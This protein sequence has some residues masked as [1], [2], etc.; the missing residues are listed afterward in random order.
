VDLNQL[1]MKKKGKEIV[2]A[3][4]VVSMKP[5]ARREYILKLNQEGDARDIDAGEAM[6]VAKAKNDYV[7]LGY[8]THDA[9]MS[10]PEMYGTAR[11]QNYK[12][13][14]AYIFYCGRLG[15]KKSTVATVAIERLDMMKKLVKREPERV[16]EF[17][18][19]ARRIGTADFKRWCRQR[20]K[21]GEKVAAP[22][23]ERET[24]AV[25]KAIEARPYGT[26]LI[27]GEVRDWLDS[28]DDDTV[29]IV[30]PPE[31]AAKRKDTR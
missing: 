10:D 2:A 22:G 12:K 31:V 3:P 16:D 17:W 9:L 14:N 23:K 26:P 1:P 11:A 13:Q 8:E 7:E 20:L 27:L 5:Q 18:T 4:T 24:K 15:I 25:K 19:Y 21:K 6:A 29:I 28:L 30:Q